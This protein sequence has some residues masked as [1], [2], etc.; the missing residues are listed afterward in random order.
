MVDT[1]VHC[2][3]YFISPIGYGLKPLDI[4]FL[5]Q[6][7]TKVNIIPIIGKADC[8][9][10]DEKEKL[11]KT[12]INQIE[13]HKISIYTLPETDEDDPIYLRQLNE[14][15]DAIPFAITSSTDKVEVNG[16][17]TLGR[18]YSFGTVD[19]MDSNHSDF[20]KLRSMLIS[21][22]QGMNDRKEMSMF[23]Y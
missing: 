2:C 18:N 7:S 17:C 11:K 19:I 13:Q 21:N 10:K 15:K 4:Q 9:T 23:C 22:L 14:I 3:F 8:L 16:K 20:L 12:I 5:Q 6:L 1:R